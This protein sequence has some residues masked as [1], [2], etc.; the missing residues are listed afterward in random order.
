MA[1]AT[2]KALAE[3]AELEK[4][5]GKIQTELSRESSGPKSDKL[6][7]ELQNQLNELDTRIAQLNETVENNTSASDLVTPK[8]VSDRTKSNSKGNT[9]NAVGAAIEGVV[10]GLLA[11]FARGKVDVIPPFER[12]INVPVYAGLMATGRVSA[13]VSAEGEVKR[14]N[15]KLEGTVM[16]KASADVLLGFS[17]AL[18]PFSIFVRSPDITFGIKLEG[19]TSGETQ[20]SLE[21]E[22]QVPSITGKMTGAAFI[23]KGE[24]ALVLE[25][26]FDFELIRR[27]AAVINGLGPLGKPVAEDKGNAGSALVWA[28]KGI[29]IFRM[30]TGEVDLTYRGGTN[31]RLTTTPPTFGLT[32]EFKGL[33]EDAQNLLINTLTNVTNAIRDRITEVTGNAQATYD[34]IKD[35]IGQFFQ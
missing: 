29:D 11:Y 26:P 25:V 15:L 6:R 1:T 30:D 5:R 7:E 24:H 28:G 2:D 10:D 31:L 35:R 19:S 22:P 12:Q 17:V 18:S 27:V 23:I 34:D 33:L 21:I 3:I 4:T 16:L 32:D 8:S 20:V 9:K 14:E 13:G